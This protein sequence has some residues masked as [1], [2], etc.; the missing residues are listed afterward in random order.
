V[1]QE[2]VKYNMNHTKKLII[3]GLIILT[4]FFVLTKTTVVAPTQPTPSVEKKAE[5]KVLQKEERSIRQSVIISPF[6]LRIGNETSTLNAS[7]ST[8]YEILNDKENKIVM[9]GKMYP[10]LGFFITDIGSL[11]SGNGKNVMYDINGREAS[12][13]VSTY[14]PQKG[15]IIEFKLK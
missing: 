9:T 6:T 12:M 13:G 8:L 15:D 2:S 7:G 3:Y 1:W 14:V 11:H 5:V 10:G 4:G